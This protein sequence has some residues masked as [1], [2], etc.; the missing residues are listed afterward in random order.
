MRKSFFKHYI[1]T[2]SLLLGMT[3]C[4]WYD[5]EDDIVCDRD[6]IYV[7]CSRCGARREIRCN[8]SISTQA[9]LDIDT[10]FLEGMFADE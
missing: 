9:F 5:T 1:C 8:G 10:L 2:M 7:S 4:S 3:S 6:R